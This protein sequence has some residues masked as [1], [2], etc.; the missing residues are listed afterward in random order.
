[1]T[2]ADQYKDCFVEWLTGN[3]AGAT[4]KIG[5]VS[6]GIGKIVTLATGATLPALP[7]EGDVFRI[8]TS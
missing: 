3:N 8:I 7:V 1:V 5:A 6:N 4:R 2:N